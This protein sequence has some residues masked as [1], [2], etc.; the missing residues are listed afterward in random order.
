[1]HDVIRSALLYM[2]I[3]RYRLE[4]QIGLKLDRVHQDTEELYEVNEFIDEILPYLMKKKRAH[5]SAIRFKQ[6]LYN[7]WHYWIR[8]E[9]AKLNRYLNIYGQDVVVKVKVHDGFYNF[10]LTFQEKT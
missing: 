2:K 3:H 7:K 4:D 10:I 5:D 6:D 9:N 8:N 1:M